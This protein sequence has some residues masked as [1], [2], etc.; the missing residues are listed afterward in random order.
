MHHGTCVTHVPWCM[1]GSLT[2]CD[3]E[4]VPGIP[5]AC[6]S[7][8]LRIWKEAHGAFVR[9]MILIM[10]RQITEADHPIPIDYTNIL[11]SVYSLFN[12]F[13]IC[14]QIKRHRA[15]RIRYITMECQG[16]KKIQD[17]KNSY[18]NDCLKPRKLFLIHD[19]FTLQQE[20]L[21]I[22]KTL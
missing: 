7:A 16:W 14:L 20:P 17:I 9:M 10:P 1:S 11:D 6:A 13:F 5:G 3:G 21:S 18:K 12:V 22:C 8:I 2:C 19:L 15:M 4:N